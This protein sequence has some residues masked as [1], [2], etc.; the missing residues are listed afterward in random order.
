MRRRLVPL[1]VIL[2]LAAAGWLAW[3]SGALD[4]LAAA[5]GLE[6]AVTA[7]FSGY[8]EADYVMV[9]SAVGGPLRTLDVRRGDTVAAGA[10]LFA[11]D[12]VAE[13]AARAEAEARLRQAEAQLADLLTGRR[14]PEIEAIEAQHAQAMATLQ[15]A[16][17]DYQRQA[18]LRAS[19]TSSAAQL[20]AARARRDADRA[21]VAELEAD[22]RVA[23]LPAR[24][25]AIRAAQA[26]VEAAQAAL[27]QAEW[28]LEQM[29]GSAPAGALVVD[30]LYEP[31]EMVP[32]ASPIVQL[33]PP[34]NLKIRFFVPET[35]LG[36]MAIGQRVQVGCDGCAGPI[37]ATIRFIAPEAEF[38]PPV[39]Y[40]REERSRLVF[41]VEARPAPGAM[42]LRVGQPVDVTLAQP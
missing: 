13:L 31:G 8:V 5:L 28:R 24:E 30:T 25:E 26:A 16:E 42:P 10:S 7:G 3:R 2:G 38:T 20:D 14:D 15:E 36:G 37:D 12:D 32:A 11:L 23:R 18:N 6:P 34:E 39:I 33:L 35:I 40:S 41:M 19:G 17:R 29:R 4:R 22:L 9:A 27:A 21:R 1:V